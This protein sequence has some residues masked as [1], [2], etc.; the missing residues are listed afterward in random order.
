VIVG[1]RRGWL[2]AA[3]VGVVAVGL[4][5]MLWATSGDGTTSSAAVDAEVMALGARTYAVHCATCHGPAG[6]GSPGWRTRGPDGHLPPPPHDA[7]GHTWHHGDGLLFRIVRDGCDAYPP[8]ARDRCGMPAFGDRL[9]GA[10]IRAVIEHL[11]TWW[12][13]EERAYQADRS[14]EDPYP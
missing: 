9:A 10:E 14:R 2:L 8:S 5:G 4:G 1:T 12:G 11:K 6:E 3:S 13:E 7:S